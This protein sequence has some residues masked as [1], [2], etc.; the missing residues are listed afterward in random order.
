MVNSF[1]FL[2]DVPVMFYILHE[3]IQILHEN[4]LNAILFHNDTSEKNNSLNDNFKE[5]WING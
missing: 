4:M 3:M 5:P 1:V 2:L